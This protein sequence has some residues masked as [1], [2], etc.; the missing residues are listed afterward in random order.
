MCT[1]PKW[2]VL[3]YQ[4]IVTACLRTLG[5][6]N[7]ECFTA[8]AFMTPVNITILCPWHLFPKQGKESLEVASLDCDTRCSSHFWAL[9]YCISQFSGRAWPKP[10]F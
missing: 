9:F 6:C 2:R 4:V 8:V 1:K 7:K 3:E 5:R 10:S